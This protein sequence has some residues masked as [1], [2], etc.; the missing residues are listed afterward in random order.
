MPKQNQSFSNVAEILGPILA[1]VAV[2]DQPWLLA[3]AERMAAE[4]YRGWAQQ[5]GDAAD[6]ALLLGCAERED[7]IASRIESL[8]PDAKAVQQRLRQEHPELVELNR[9]LFAG[10]PLRE[11][12]A[13]QAKGE[14]LGAATWKTVA[15]ASRH[16]AVRE[17]F[18]AC[19]KLEEDSAQVLET[20]LE[21]NRMI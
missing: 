10:R 11:Q 2:T 18:L 13:I 1:R 4:R 17:L 8:R 19:A 9:V 6:K 16:P 7:E 14:R 20:M 12:Y 21:R 5:E 15:N 3:L